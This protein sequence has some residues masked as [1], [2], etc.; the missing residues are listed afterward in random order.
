MSRGWNKALRPLL[1]GLLA[2]I[3]IGAYLLD[4]HLKQWPDDG[5]ALEGDLVVASAQVPA[6]W[7]GFASSRAGAEVLRALSRPWGEVERTA[8]LATGI[9]P[10]PIRW[11]AWLGDRAV[12]SLRDDGTWLLCVRPGVLVHALYPLVVGDAARLGAL[13][14]TW[15]D[16]YLLIAPKAPTSVVPGPALPLDALPAPAVHA[17][18]AS[19]SALAK[20]PLYVGL[21]GVE[22]LPVLLGWD[23]S[24][25]AMATAGAV[26]PPADGGERPMVAVTAQGDAAWTDLPLWDAVARATGYARAEVI[27]AVSLR[28]NLP[29]SFRYPEFDAQHVVHR[30]LFDLVPSAGVAIRHTGWSALRTSAPWTV[31]PFAAMAL[32]PPLQTVPYAWDD[33]EGF[34][35]PVL[36]EDFTLGCAV[37]GAWA[38]AANP[39]QNLPRALR[40]VPG[41]PTGHAALRV[42]VDWSRLAPAIQ[43]LLLQRQSLGLLPGD[44][45]AFD[46]EYAPWTRALAALG[47]T[48]LQ[49]AQDHVA[50]ERSL[51]RGHLALAPAV[52]VPQP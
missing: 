44:P 26:I 19:G 39:P 9:R 28:P 1:A 17:W 52:A 50:P 18:I 40:A 30:T 41:I 16:G 25:G 29:V 49:G 27:A 3:A 7:S 8:R 38:H 35:I 42:E 12:F 11:G 32:E 15:Q 13:S 51:L 5:L 34:L 2:V 4:A 20:G 37:Q 47:Q 10:T 36:G 48:V 14:V 43:R 31:H 46:A 24:E 6:A 45:R 22:D 23:G 21:A 33:V